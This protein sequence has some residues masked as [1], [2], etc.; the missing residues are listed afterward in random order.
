MD[1]RASESTSYRRLSELC[2]IQTEILYV[3][4]CNKIVYQ[5]SDN[6]GNEYEYPIVSFTR[7]QNR[8]NQLR[9][10][11]RKESEQKH[12]SFVLIDDRIPLQ[13]SLTWGGSQ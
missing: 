10:T 3:N 5:A 8:Q 13:V 1:K 12:W 7:Y 2:P 4:Q 6:T 11:L 9:Y